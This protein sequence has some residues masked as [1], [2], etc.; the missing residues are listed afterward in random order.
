VSPVQIL[1]VN[2]VTAVTLALAL[3]FE[4]TEPEAMRRPPRHPAAPLFS[5]YFVW[6]TVLVSAVLFMGTIGVFL[7]E[8]EQGATLERAR[9]AAVNTLVLFEVFYLL[10]TRRLLAP[11][12]P[13]HVLR[14]NPY[15]PLTIVAIVLLQLAFTYAPFMHALFA[16][17]PL[18]ALDWLRLAAIAFTVFVVVEL[19]KAMTRRRRSVLR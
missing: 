9:T 17:E 6:R 3:A 13:A 5:R 19:E 16:T 10:N 1:W 2:M 18:L 7:W 15:V 12:L 4:P 11:A 14:G 8:L